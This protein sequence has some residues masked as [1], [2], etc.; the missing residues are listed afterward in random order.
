MESAFDCLAVPLPVESVFGC[1]T[2]PLPVESAFCC[3]AAVP[4]KSGFGCS[5][6]LAPRLPFVASG[7]VRDVGVAAALPVVAFVSVNL[8]VGTAEFALDAAFFL[9]LDGPREGFFEAGGARFIDWAVSPIFFPLFSVD[10]F[11]RSSIVSFL[12]VAGRVVDEG[13]PS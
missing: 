1:L 13:Y 6:L 10:V 8:G 2:L 11:P 4:L 5:A 3:L 9:V 12:S 7:V